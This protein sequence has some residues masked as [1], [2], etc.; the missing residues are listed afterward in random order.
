MDHPLLHPMTSL[1]RDRSR[2]QRQNRFR[3]RSRIRN[4]NQVENIHDSPMILRNRC[5]KNFPGHLSEGYQSRRRRRWRTK[6]YSGILHRKKILAHCRLPIQI[7]IVSFAY[8][9][10]NDLNIYRIQIFA[11]YY[12]L[13]HVYFR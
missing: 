12:L 3:R 8:E 5:Q 7:H 13:I 6:N 1:R 9:K 4:P 2:R 10:L 11:R